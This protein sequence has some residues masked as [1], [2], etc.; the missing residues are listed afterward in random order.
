MRS[1]VFVALLGVFSLS[2][3]NPDAFD[4]EWER[5]KRGRTYAPAKT[6]SVT[7]QF[8][9]VD[10]VA[11][12]T[13]IDVPAAY[14]PTRRWPVRVQ[15]HGG[16]NRP[17]E[18]RRPRAYPLSASKP[19]ITV[20]PRAWN[21][22]QWWHANQVDNIF[23][24]LDRLKREYNV[25]ESRVYVTGFSDGAT[26]AFFL[27]MR[28]PTPFC[29]IMP[30]HGSL[31][32]LA[33]PATRPDGQMHP[34]NL[35][36]RPLFATNGGRDPLYPAAA[37]APT[38]KLLERAGVTMVYLP[39]PEAGHDLSWWPAG[40]EH[41]ERFL[42][43][44][45]RQPHPARLSWEA[46]RTDRYNRVD[47]LVIT[48]LGKT[49]AD[50][51]L[52]DVTAGVFP[53]PRPSGRVDVVRTGN[54]FEARTRGVRRFTLLLSPDA[55]DFAKPVAV[56]VNGRTVFEGKIEKDRGTL[57]KWAERDNDRNVLYGAELDVE[58]K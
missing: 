51:P 14:D 50:Q 12:E 5:L 15:L 57:R 45:P 20:Y 29:A 37:I 18:R 26:G 23:R 3:Q 11:F 8:A 28:A 4:A 56:V 9:S 58:V 48:A 44:H 49:P 47:W 32:V 52:D 43:K 54:S 46:E 27:G 2:T 22:A 31:E 36:N 10:G 33:N 17:L 25:D 42:T 38:M 19:E 41:F 21:A 40:R 39:V 34:A 1:V 6:G 7:Y 55:I 13:E 53:R 16:V 30:L 24:V 35:V